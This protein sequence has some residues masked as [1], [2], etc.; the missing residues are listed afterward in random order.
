MGRKYC[1]M[2][3]CSN[4]SSTLT[5]DGKKVTL[6]RLPMAESKVHIKQQWIRRLRNVRGNLIVNDNT[7]VCSEHFEGQLTETSVPTIFPSKPLKD[8]PKP[9][10]PLI[11][12]SM[13]NKSNMGLDWLY[14][15]EQIDN[16]NS[17]PI[18]NTDKTEQQ[19]ILNKQNVDAETNT[20]PVIYC[21]AET[22]TDVWFTEASTQTN[23]P[24]MMPEDLRNDEKT[25]FY[26]GFIS[27]A[28]FWHYFQTIK[29]MVQTSYTTGKEIKGQQEL[30]NCISIQII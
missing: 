26:T 20:E 2:P 22:Q 24:H 23:L 28:M 7:R 11:R 17:Q 27:L 30:R 12:H 1:C 19:K 3:G 14:H 13:E 5:P 18:S 16:S 25:R 8:V 21:V 29:N 10:R 9:R 15:D 6:H 4:T